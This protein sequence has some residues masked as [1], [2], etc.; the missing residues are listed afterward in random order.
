MKAILSSR[1]HHYVERVGIFLVMVALIVGMPGCGPAS[2]GSVLQ[3][4]LNALSTLGGMV[5]ILAEGTSPYPYGATVELV[6]MSDDGYRFVQWTGDVEDIDDVTSPTITITMNRTYSITANFIAQYNLTID[7]TAGGSVTT[8]GE[9]TRTYDTGTVVNLVAEAEAG[10]QFVNWTGNVSTVANVTATITNIT[11]NGN[12]SIT[13]NFVQG[14]LIRTWYDLDAIRNNLGCSYLLMNDLDSTTAGYEELASPTANRGK[15]WQPIGTTAENDK[16]VGSFNGQGHVICNLFI[17]C[18]AKSNVGLFGVVGGG[19]VIENVGLINV[20]VTGYSGVGGLMGTN[21]GTTSN[22]YC[23]GRVTGGW[24]VGGLVG[25]NSGNVSNSYC[26]G[27]VTGGWSVGGLVGQNSGSVSDSYCTGRVT[28]GCGVGGLAGQNEGTASN[29]FSSGSVTGNNY[30]GGLVGQNEGTASNCS[31]SGSVTGNNYVGG[32]VGQNEGTASNC[33]S[34]GSVTG[35]NY[36]GG[37]IGTNEGTVSDSYST[38]S[39]TGNTRVG[40]LV[41]QNSNAVSNSYSSGRVTGNTRIGGLVGRNGGTVSNSFWDTQTSGQ[42]S[43]AGGMGRTTAQMKDITT[44]SVAGWNIIGVTNSS[45]RNT[46]YIWNIVDDV[47]YPFL[48][49]QPV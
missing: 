22:S 29:C 19:G 37:L 23:T 20:T 34:S 11:M 42:G 21:E 44:F 9:G 46:G 3:Y 40:G 6:A 41:G 27:R 39:A 48:R 13:A 49:W 16:F 30:V 8:P 15:G 7:S 5:T 1:M 33:F 2:C 12:Y 38:S 18:P 25:H 36:V 24:S 45:T 47:T 10:Y 28:G 4:A 43:S 14:Q 32:L 26:T 31:S 35:N 17:D